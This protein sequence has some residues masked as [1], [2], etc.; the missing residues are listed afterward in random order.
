VRPGMNEM[1]IR[2]D[3]PVVKLRNTMLDPLPG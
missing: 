2:Y 1:S 3:T